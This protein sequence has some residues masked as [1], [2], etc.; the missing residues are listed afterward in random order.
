MKLRCWR[1]RSALIS[2]SSVGPL[3]AAVPR[4]VVALAVVVVLAVGVVVLLVVGHQVAQREPVV[5]GD[6]VD[7]G[8]RPAPGVLVEVGRSGQAVGELVERGGLA[9]PEV[10]D[11]VAVLA[12]PLRPLRREVAHLVAARPDVPRLGDELDL[13][14]GRILLHEFEERRQ[15]V[16]VVE[17]AGQRRGQVEPEAVDVHLGHPVPQRVHDQLQRVRVPDVEAVAG[18]GVVHVV[19]LVVVDQPVVR[20]VVDA[21]HR[22][23]RAHVVAL[24][25]VV[26]DHVEDD[27]DARLVQGAHH[28]LELLHLAAGRAWRWSTWGRGRRIR[29]CCSPSS[30]TGPCRSGWSRWRSGA[31]ASARSR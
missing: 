9:A 3:D 16:D 11:G 27:L 22:Q 14:D 26:V 4:P 18:A 24:G 31:P 13:A 21:A 25:G 8:D 2:G 23:R 10:A 20:G 29:S 6:E 7:R 5:G 15:P 12:V 19:A 28:R 17:L 1:A 30:S